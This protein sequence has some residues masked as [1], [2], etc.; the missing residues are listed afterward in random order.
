MK[1]YTKPTVEVVNLK[2]SKDIATS[3]KVLRDK[4][5]QNYLFSNA[6]E[7]KEYTVSCYSTE[8]STPVNE[9]A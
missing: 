1:K 9:G 8:L 4:F 7:A 3:Y 6:A 2:S 5:T